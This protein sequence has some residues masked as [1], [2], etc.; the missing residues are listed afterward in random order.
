MRLTATDKAIGELNMR[1]ADLDRATAIVLKYGVEKAT[2]GMTIEYADIDRCIEL[3]RA[4]QPAPK[5]EKAAKVGKP[6]K[7]RKGTAEAEG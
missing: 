6:R 3:L 2:E 7:S 5:P 4:V 1:K